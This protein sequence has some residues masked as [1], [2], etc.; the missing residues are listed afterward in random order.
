[1]KDSLIGLLIVGGVLAML[2][3]CQIDQ[4]SGSVEKKQNVSEMRRQDLLALGDMCLQKSEDCLSS[5]CA[6]GYAT[7]ALAYYKR[8]ESAMDH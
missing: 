5:E 2:I 7:Q 6:G 4:Q 3:G 1:M 8:A